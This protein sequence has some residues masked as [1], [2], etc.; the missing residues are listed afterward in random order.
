MHKKH[1]FLFCTLIF[2]SLALMS[3][4]F[5]A[6]Y[7]PEKQGVF[8]QIIGNLLKT[9]GAGIAAGIAGLI[10]LLFDFCRK[11]FA[12]MAKTR[13]DEKIQELGVAAVQDIEAN[14]FKAMKR[15]ALAAGEEKIGL[16]RGKACIIEAAGLWWENIKA[17]GLLA[18]IGNIAKDDFLKLP[19]VQKKVQLISDLTKG[20]LT[21]GNDIKLSLGKIDAAGYEKITGAAVNIKF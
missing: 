18:E 4:D 11:K 10:A 7:Q 19:Q 12:W 21:L 6:T 9:L 2:F 20:K 16:E 3:A 5:Q 8:D 14:F 17:A 1:L 15:E 13:I